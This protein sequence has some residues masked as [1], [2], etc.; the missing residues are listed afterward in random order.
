MAGLL[1]T[2][3]EVAD[4][5]ESGLRIFMDILTLFYADDTI[6]FSDT[7]LGL[8]F[9]LEELENYC[10]KWKLTVNEGKTKI[11][12]ITWGRYRNQKYEFFYNNQQLECVD[13]FIYLGICF[14]KKGLTN[15]AIT[16]RETASKKA[17]FSFMTKCK[18]NHLPIEVQLDVFQKTVVPCMLYGGELWGFNKA[19]CLEII[20]K[21]FLKYSLK[22]KMSTPTVM[23]YLETGYFPIECEISIK[24]ITFWV[25]LLTGRQ[26]KLSYKIYRVCL[27]LYNRG[28]IIFKWMDNVVQILNENGYSSIFRDQLLLDSK[29]LQNIFLPKLKL[30][31]RDQARQVLLGK[32]NEGDSFYYYKDLITFHGLQ[33]Y[34]YKMPPDIWIPLIKIRTRNHK[35]P[36]ELQSWNILFKPRNERYCN[37]CNLNEVGDEFHF[38]ARC[39]IFL[40][41]RQ[42]YIPSILQ[43]NSIRNFISILKSDDI[44][45]L[46]GLAKFLNILFEVFE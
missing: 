29:Y 42:K 38:I 1:S 41:D 46:R 18:Q 19:E 43:D 4:F 27:A 44:K 2:T 21:K 6:I 10:K 13:D 11:M 32:L 30:T 24:I 12:C 33:N 23:L 40:E 34:L 16:Y 7:A 15:K 9:A 3:G 8:Q 36:V 26:D 28:L 25:N 45:I 31:V 39:P 37:V 35:L 14:T 5:E 17:M 22:L 20:Q